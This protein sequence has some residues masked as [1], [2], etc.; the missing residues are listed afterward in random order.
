MVK[1][2]ATT[3]A[4]KIRQKMAEFTP[5][6]RKLINKLIANYP[7]AG[8]SSITEF[9]DNGGVS[10]PTV[11]R[12]LK[13]LGFSGFPQFQQALKAELKATLSTPLVKHDQ[14]STSAPETHIL[15]QFATATMDNLR[16][17][18]KQID[19]TTF[20]A[21]SRMIA[22]QKAS[23]HIIG[24]RISH[25]VA[26]HLFTHLQIIREQVFLLPDSA[27][28][29]PNQLLNMHAND[30]LVIFDVRRYESDLEQLAS[31]AHKQGIRVILFTDQWMSPVSAYATQIIN[32]RIEVPSSWDSAV[33]SVFII[34]ALIASI[35][36]RTW[37]KTS[38]RVEDLESLLDATQRFR[39]QP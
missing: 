29:W 17:S 7:M 24:G 6:E 2:R 11:M 22:D 36:N 21:I 9:A 30:V 28:L 20:D 32:V 34:E 25:S 16:E 18:L 38:K 19:H 15:N 31:L 10:T 27:G 8:I 13:K 26:D 12:M 3:V 35:A 37:K 5:S 14:W 4:E 1:R 39:K 33:V 23:I